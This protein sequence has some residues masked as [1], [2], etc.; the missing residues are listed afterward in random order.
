MSVSQPGNV[1]ILDCTLRDGGYFNNWQF[2]KK[3][4]HALVSS[5]NAAGVDIIEIGY[6]SPRSHREKNFEMREKC[7]VTI[8][9]QGKCFW[10]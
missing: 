7:Y 6:K 8:S 4:A 10:K 5:L 9:A 2:N 3:I 1:T